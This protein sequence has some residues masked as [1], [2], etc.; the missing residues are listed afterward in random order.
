MTIDLS[1][2]HREY[3]PDGSYFLFQFEKSIGRHF[4]PQKFNRVQFCVNLITSMQFTLL[5]KSSPKVP[6]CYKTMHAGT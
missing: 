1:N 4:C 3:S 2:C 5:F 6:V